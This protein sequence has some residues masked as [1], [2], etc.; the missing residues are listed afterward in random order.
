[1]RCLARVRAPGICLSSCTISSSMI[2]YQVIM[3]LR[4]VDWEIIDI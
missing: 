4:L 1:M 3:C 2:F